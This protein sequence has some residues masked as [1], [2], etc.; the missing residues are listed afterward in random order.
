MTRE[1]LEMAAVRRPRCR[2]RQSRQVRR[3]R[4]RF[5]FEAPA[6]AKRELWHCGIDTMPLMDHGG[7]LPSGDADTFAE[8]AV[9]LQARLQWHCALPPGL[10]EQNRDYIAGSR[11]ELVAFEC[12]VIWKE[13]AK[14]A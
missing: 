9:G 13:A 10:W 5:S 12:P 4:E 2:L 1:I 7:R 3:R 11:D 6:R 14:D 8:A